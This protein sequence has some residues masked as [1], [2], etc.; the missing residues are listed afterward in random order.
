MSCSITSHERSSSARVLAVSKM[1]LNKVKAMLVWSL[2]P[3][4]IL[5]CLVTGIVMRKRKQSKNKKQK[6]KYSMIIMNTINQRDME[7][8]PSMVAK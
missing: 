8:L 4:S 2:R 5:G 1:V 7:D 3:C 6:Q